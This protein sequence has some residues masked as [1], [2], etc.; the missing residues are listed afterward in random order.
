MI[1]NRRS[2]SATQ[3]DAAL[4]NAFK[5]A[6]TTIISDNL[7]RFPGA[8]GLRPFHKVGSIM[9]GTALTVRT[10]TGDNLALH[11]ALEMVRPGDVI[12]VDGGGDTT[13]ALAGEIMM[14]IAQT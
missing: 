13:R 14:T 9:V 3:A 7:A 4:I 11:Q 1:G 5:T 8:V 2:P 12:V 10:Y 6:A